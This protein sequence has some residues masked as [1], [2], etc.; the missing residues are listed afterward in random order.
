MGVTERYLGLAIG[1][2]LWLVA[3]VSPSAAYSPV[4]VWPEW[5][6]PR[7]TPVDFV[8]PYGRFRMPIGYFSEPY[9]LPRD[10][11]SKGNSGT[12]EFKFPDLPFRF[13]MPNGQM[14][15]NKDLQFGAYDL[16]GHPDPDPNKYVV[17]FFRMKRPDLARFIPSEVK[18]L[19]SNIPQRTLYEVPQR[20][21]NA[22][23]WHYYQGHIVVPVTQDHVGMTLNCD[24][25][26]C[27]GPV[28]FQRENIIFDV[29]IPPDRMHSTF[30]IAFEASELLAR[31]KAD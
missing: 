8:T 7:D 16:E 28:Y 12:A 11:A 20:G 26:N 9:S 22:V 15:G 29:L 24:E 5:L 30:Q 4:Y 31:W 27:Y 13:M 6:P 17:W 1:A 10:L 23:S 18:I 3:T 25:R 14:T 2:A 19:S 21:S